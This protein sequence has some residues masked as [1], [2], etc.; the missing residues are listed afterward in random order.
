[1]ISFPKEVYFVHRVGDQIAL[2]A[3]VESPK[4]PIENVLVLFTDHAKAMQFAEI[5]RE[6]PVE[7]GSR[8][9][10]RED[11]GRF[12]DFQQHRTLA[13]AATLN[14]GIHDGMIRGDIWDLQSL[15]DRNY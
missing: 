6:F 15:I 3:T 9:G 5:K 12:F 1:M 14:P 2:T 4:G 13:T 11:A 8:I 7:V 10:T